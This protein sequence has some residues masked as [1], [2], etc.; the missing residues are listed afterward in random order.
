MRIKWKHA[1]VMGIIGACIVAGGSAYGQAKAVDLEAN[2]SLTIVSASDESYVTDI[3]SRTGDD[4]IIYDVYQIAE[5]I[6]DDKY[7]T[8]SY[9][10]PEGV[11]FTNSED[12]SE[13]DIATY[14]GL[15]KL[16][17]SSW[18]DIAQQAAAIVKDELGAE[19]QTFTKQEKLEE[20]PSGLY[21]VIAHG[22]MDPYFDTVND[23]LVTYYESGNYK[24]SYTPV[25]V[26][27]PS[28][29][30][31]DG[32]ELSTA[33]TWQNDV[34]IKLK[35]ERVDRLEGITITKHIDAWENSSPVTFI[36]EVTA[37]KEGKVVYS[38]V[39][40]LTFDKDSKDTM[41]V[42]L[43]NCIPVGSRVEV[44]EIYSGAGYKF[45]EGENGE[46][47]IEVLEEQPNHDPY[48]IPDPFNNTYNKETTN[49][50][51]IENHFT[52]DYGENGSRFEW[53]VD[54]KLE[55]RNEEE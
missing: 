27:L 8:F 15:T 44:E 49:G 42:S 51:G 5:T 33:G 1:K 40:S 17:A 52:A 22:N 55:W 2:K 37:T 34:T 26:S 14:E 35:P 54:N 53:Q 28:T 16:Q 13:Y 23:K 46:R 18:D 43:K 20:M 41:S 3:S 38:N 36:F 12:E 19:K 7:E 47:V 25:L 29:G 32:T 4:A 39:V 31:V 11:K 50:F 21:L 30:D 10:L 48:V 6:P 24:Y 9:K 45:A